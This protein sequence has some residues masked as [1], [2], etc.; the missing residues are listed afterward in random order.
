MRARC[1]ALAAGGGGPGHQR[2]PSCVERLGLSAGT[3]V[4]V[5]CAGRRCGL[6]ARGLGARLLPAHLQPSLRTLGVRP[7]NGF[8]G[9]R[10]GP[11][12]DWL[13]LPRLLW[14]DVKLCSWV[15]RRTAGKA[16]DSRVAKVGGVKLCLRI[17]MENTL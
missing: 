6:W 2:A 3:E 8:R 9:G 12:K 13:S 10:E 16:L 15:R 7:G 5:G 1:A 14:K 4:I 11:G 17:S